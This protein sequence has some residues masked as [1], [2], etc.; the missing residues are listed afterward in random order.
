MGGAL[1]GGLVLIFLGLAFYLSYYGYFRS[2]RW[3]ALILVALGIII[4]IDDL[5][6]FAKGARRG[7]GVI[8][9]LILMTIGYALYADISHWWPLI[10]VA[11]G[12]GIIASAMLARARNPAPKSP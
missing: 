2:G 12:I 11:I 1:I 4:I 5:Y 7:A 8:G 6:Y 3:W 10:L 9:G